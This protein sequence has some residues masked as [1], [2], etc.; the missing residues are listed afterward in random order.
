MTWKYSDGR[1]GIK[2]HD[3]SIDL[4]VTGTGRFTDTVNFEE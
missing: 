1:V 2:Q 4:D 3:P